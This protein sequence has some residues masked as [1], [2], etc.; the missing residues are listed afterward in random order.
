MC[1]NVTWWLVSLLYD[2]LGSKHSQVLEESKVGLIRKYTANIQLREVAR[3]FDFV[4]ECT[5]NLMT[6]DFLKGIY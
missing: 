3:C 4:L 2:D 1:R 6:V 5:G